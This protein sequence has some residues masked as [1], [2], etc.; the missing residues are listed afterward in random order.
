MFVLWVKTHVFKFYPH[1][2]LTFEV[3]YILVEFYDFNFKAKACN[4]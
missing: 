4:T 3:D 1:F 2:K